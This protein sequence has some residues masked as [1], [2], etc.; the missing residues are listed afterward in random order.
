[1]NKA[2]LTLLAYVPGTVLALVAW[3][4]WQDVYASREG[5]SEERHMQMLM[6]VAREA[7]QFFGLLV[8]SCV[9]FFAAVALHLW[10]LRKH[11][12]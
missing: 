1:M 11:P 7:P 4:L 10:M 9:L 3:N 12:S 8:G 6:H 5:T 2:L